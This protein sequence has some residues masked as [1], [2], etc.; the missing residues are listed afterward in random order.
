[1]SNTTRRGTVAVITMAN[2]PMNTMSHANRSAVKAA[3]EAAIAD[4]EVKAIVI[5]G[6][7]RVYS[8]G[9]EI[10]EF[11]TPAA[12]ASPGLGEVIKTLED[13]PKPVVAAI[14]GVAMGGGLELALGCHYRVGA[15]GA[16]IALPEV[17]LGLLPGAGGTQRLPRLV[18]VQKGLDMI[19]S[20]EPVKS[21]KF[22]PGTLF[23]E[24]TE[25]DLVAAACAFAEKVAAK[26][27]PFKRARDLS[28][29]VDDA[30][31]FFATA[32]AKVA[33]DF[34]GY[35]APAKC[36]AAVEAVVTMPFDEGLKFERA[37]FLELV[38]TTES[39]AMRHYFFGERIV[40][41]IPDVPDDTPLRE[42]KS[43]AV[44]GA[45]TM[46]GGITMNFINAG[47]PVTLLE[48]R[49]DA[50]DRGV[51]IIR[52][53][54]ENT[55]K[56]GRM[57]IDEVEKRMAL[58]KPTLSYDDLKGADMVVEAV[59]EDMAVKETV[60]KKL[61][62]VMKPGAILASN[63]STLDVNKIAEFTRRPQDVIG[64]HFFS[65]AN[66]MRLLEI[67]RGAATAKDVLATTMKLSKTIRKIGVVAG[68]CDG[69]IGNRMI[70][71]YSRQAG[72]LLD[73]GAS[74]EQVDRAIEKI[75]FAMGPFRMGDLAGN[76]VGWYIRKRRYV[77]K[78]DLHY[79]KTA[80]LICEAG[81]YG[82]KTAAGW[83][84]YKAGDRTA[85]ASP[86]VEDILVKYRQS[87]G[88][89][90]RQIAD[91]EIVERLMYALVNEGALLLE[92][93]IAMRAV[94]ID[95]IYMTGYGVPPYLG[96]PM[97]WADRKGLAN[98]VATMQRFAQNPNADPAFWKPAPLLAKLAAE[99]KTF[100]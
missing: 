91:E 28:V 18:G 20:G 39:K 1:M 51:A 34:R 64:T 6:A 78:P 73:E 58:I 8:S 80:D 30:A 24:I 9:A 29:A 76:D 10:K 22:A 55:A 82:Q 87:I 67:V 14:H 11:N 50:L 5:T 32:K 53:N 26:G 27:A 44:V 77:E 88:I 71:Q 86:V 35:P 93:G 57:T 3:V 43:A 75:G 72:F 15:P 70:E 61:D 69:F 46:G 85:Y 89:T 96:G 41:K 56:K 59:F 36:V 19:T 47:I 48:M 25:G 2:P 40:A 13:S 68:V 90:S 33:K 42:V 62:E 99:G 38:A 63:T 83:Y 65:P 94:D 12:T 97:F 52:K 31:E 17:K 45:G 79:S 100:N 74:P 23:D 37:A 81:R 84:D 92:E 7:G 66:V 95:M 16:L 60:F 98:V 4:A 49:Q 54:Y 21:E